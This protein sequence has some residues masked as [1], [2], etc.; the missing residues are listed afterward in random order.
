M[1]IAHGANTSLLKRVILHAFDE[2][3]F[4]H[5]YSHGKADEPDAARQELEIWRKLRAIAN[6]VNDTLPSFII[7]K[8]SVLRMQ[9]FVNRDIEINHPLIRLLCALADLVYPDNPRGVLQ[10]R[11]LGLDLS[12]IKFHT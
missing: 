9:C 3:S 11:N 1:S 5:V 2:N 8:N 6:C 10:R 4:P 7:D 12:T